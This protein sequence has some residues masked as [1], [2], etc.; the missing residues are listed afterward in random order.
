MKRQ[1]TGARLL[2]TVAVLLGSIVSAAAQGG[3]GFGAPPP[4]DPNAPTPRLP[5]GKPDLTGSWGGAVNLTGAG[6]PGVTVGDMFRRCTPFQS[7]NCMEWT[8]QSEDWPFMSGMRLDMRQPM[9]KPEFWDK[10]IE[11]DQ[12]TNREDPVMTCLPLGVP[13]QGPPAR[14]FATDTD[15]T[16]IYRAGVDGAGGYAEFRMIPIDGKPHDP[17]RANNYTYF[18]YTVGRWEGDTLVLDSIGFSDETWLGRGGFF[19]TDKMRAIEKFTRKGNQLLY[20]V[21]IEDPDVLLEP[22]V[23]PA[24]TL[25][26]SPTNAIIAERGSCTETE[27]NE[28]STQYRH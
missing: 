21:T 27:H 22:W 26:L 11:L 4:A 19:H 2:A 14:I 20:E 25:R 5:N 13:R 10:I 7:K 23:M 8:N 28:V 3:G 24:R 16:F 12:W 18:G 1:M 6:A 15:I 9:Y 17:R